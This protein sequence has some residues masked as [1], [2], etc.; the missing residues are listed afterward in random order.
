MIWMSE[1]QKGAGDFLLSPSPLVGEGK[2]P[3]PIPR[4]RPINRPG[5]G[6]GE[7]II[8]EI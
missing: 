2:G 5:R 7:G 6:K 4:S 8:G 3:S 1:S